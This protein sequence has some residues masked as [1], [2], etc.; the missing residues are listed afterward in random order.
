MLIKHVHDVDVE[1]E[2]IRV[3]KKDT[4]EDIAK[5]FETSKVCDP[6]HHDQICS[7]ILS[8]YVIEKGEPI[9]IINKDNII[10]EV[11]VNGKDPKKITAEEIMNDPILCTINQTIQEAINLIIDKGILTV[12]VCDGKELVSV[13]SI[14]DAIFLYHEMDDI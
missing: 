14:Y 3:D 8:A 10:A 4:I 1:D 5:R 6:E 2:Y 11:I 7:P 9:G 13:I 12:G